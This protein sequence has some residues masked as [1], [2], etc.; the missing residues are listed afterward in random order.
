MSVPIIH[1]TPHELLQRRAE[2]LSRLGTSLEDIEERADWY[3]LTP[4]EEV[5]WLELREIAFLLD[6]RR[7]R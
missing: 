7:A 2:I 6:D 3:A 5:A 4:D 1:V